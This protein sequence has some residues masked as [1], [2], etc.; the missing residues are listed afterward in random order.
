MLGHAACL[1]RMIE[2]FL[3]HQTTKLLAS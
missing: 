3:L 1:G 2:F